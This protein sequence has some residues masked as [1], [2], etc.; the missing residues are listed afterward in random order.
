MDMNFEQKVRERAYHIW[1]SAGMMHGSAHEHWVIAEKAVAN[2]TGEPV[3]ARP[4]AGRRGQ[5]NGQN[6]VHQDI[7]R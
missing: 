6:I 2:E 4:E 7:V 3:S 1:M 5:G